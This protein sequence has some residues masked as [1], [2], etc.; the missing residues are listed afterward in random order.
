[1]TSSSREIVTDWI[2]NHARQDIELL[3][4]AWTSGQAA[5]F[6]DKANEIQRMLEIMEAILKDDLYRNA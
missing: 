6:R 3:S 5:A 4:K 2:G 1:M